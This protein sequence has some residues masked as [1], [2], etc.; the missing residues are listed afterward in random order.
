MSELRTIVAARIKQRRHAKGW[1]GDE[2][3]RRLSEAGS[4]QITLSTYYSWEQGV[5][6]PQ[7]EQLI[8]LGE[9]FGCPPA[10]LQGFTNSDSLSPVSTNYVTANSPSIG[11]KAGVLQIAQASAA[12]AYNL[13]YLARRGLNKNKLLSITQ[14][15][16]SMAGVIEEGDECLLD[17]ETVDVHGGDLFG[18]VVNGVVWTRWIRPQ[19]DGSFIIAA[20][21]RDQYP[22]QQ[23]SAQQFAELDIIGRVARICHE[24]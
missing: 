13:D 23:V 14:I 20:Q 12:T 11:T 4:E 24:R 22:D 19:L 10:W 5:R 9:V 8:T 1:T 17:R 21:S 18:L 15:D 3:A 6:R 7:P 2:T 16:T